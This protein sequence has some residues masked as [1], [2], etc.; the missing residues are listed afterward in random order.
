LTPA[1]LRIVTRGGFEFQI[2][3]KYLERADFTSGRITYVSDLVI[4]Q[5]TITPA[6]GS[7]QISESLSRFLYAPRMD[8]DF[9][10]SVLALTFP[11]TNE[12]RQYAKGMALHSRTKLTYRL[13]E[14]YQRLRG[15][16]GLAPLDAGGGSVRLEIALDGKPL[17]E[18]PILRSGDP[19]P[20]DIE[21]NGGKLLTILVDYGD[22][23]DTG[24]R[25]H[26]CNLRATK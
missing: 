21:I 4:A 5:Q 19:V 1:G 11:S 22:D 16:V 13:R 26:L 10:G 3:P 23:G 25:V 9:E 17:F 18:Q 14:E 12:T 6:I 20:I 15:I 7:Q 8:R 24:D 2:D